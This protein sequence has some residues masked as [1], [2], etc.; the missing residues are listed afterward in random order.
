MD[1]E[2]IASKL[3]TQTIEEL[4]ASSPDLCSSL[5]N[6]IKDAKLGIVDVVKGLNSVLTSGNHEIRRKGIEILTK[7][8]TQLDNSHLVE[9]EIQ[10]LVDFL[11][12]RLIDHSSMES[13]SLQCLTYFLDCPN[14][15]SDYEEKLIEFV[16]NKANVQ[17]METKNRFLVYDIFR[18]VLVD[19]RKRTQTLDTDLFYS[20]I[21]VIEGE[22]SPEN[23]LQCFGTI[24]YLLKNFRDLEP[25]I[26]D[27]FEW[28]SSYYPID[29]TPRDLDGVVSVNILRDDLVRAL[30]NCFFASEMNADNLQTLLLE[31]LDSSTLN[32]K[33]ESLECLKRCYKTFPL[34]S[35]KSYVTTIWAAI[36]IECLKKK[37]LIEPKLLSCCCDI[38]AAL[39]EK[40]NEDRDTYFSF[41]SD[42]YDELSIA[43]RKP[44]MD[45]FEP[46]SRLIAH[47]A[48]P[49]LKAFN[50]LLDKILPMALSTITDSELRPVA[51][52]AYIF[53][54][55]IISHPSGEL[56]SDLS[57]RLNELTMK[58]FEYTTQDK[59]CLRLLNA[60]VRY[61]VALTKETIDAV[62]SRLSLEIRSS[63]FDIEACLAWICINYSRSDI[64]FDD[65]Q[66]DCSLPSLVKQV[67]FFSFND[68][69]QDSISKLEVKFSTYIRLLNLMFDSLPR[70]YIDQLPFQDVNDLLSHTRTIAMVL[71]DNRRIIDGIGT[72]H[73]MILNKIDEQQVNP[74]LM[75]LF[76]SSYCQSLIPADESAAD[77]STK[78]YLPIIRWILKAIVLRN[79][80][81]TVPIVNLI[82]NYIQSEKVH[83]NSALEACR[84]FS[85]VHTEHASC[86][87]EKS[88]GYQIFSLFKQKFYVESSKEI[89][90]RHEK[91][92][93][94]T[95]HKKI[96]L[97]LSIG[98]QIPNLPSNVYKKDYDWLLRQLLVVQASIKLNN[99][100]IELL[101]MIYECLQVLIENDSSQNLCGH[102]HS[103]VEAC[104]AHVKCQDSL[105]IRKL[106]LDCL[107]MLATSIEKTE[108]IK[109]RASVLRDLRERLNDKKRI[110]RQAAAK[111]ILSWTIIG[112]PLGI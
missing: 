22:S 10:V 107:S 106:G 31:K 93:N 47:V 95:E 97:I 11:L 108:L 73:A 101:S 36:R 37:E 89:R 1:I 103:V 16:K 59:E 109:L 29:Y 63:T 68:N 96:M 51:G 34:S 40:L 83:V 57:K 111:A 7:I 53:E 15:P 64:L 104:R 33:L 67:K 38:L 69:S 32:T 12:L 72:L 87:F 17:K 91:T 8:V 82:L 9:R 18:K 86:K 81:L 5:V 105:K 27:V 2:T 13:T 100:N 4:E 84:I 62:I 55:L 94:D 88:Q 14:K 19:R 65:E 6:K 74:I 75:N 23:L 20:F 41:I 76:G 54:I 66:R 79:H 3:Q 112:Q 49:E 44:E 90:I 48:Q 80:S 52:V 98:L 92:L 46:A 99:D 50:F 61:K 78:V 45:L 39:A 42:I 25:Y 60:M 30:Y 35:I 71:Q 85:F 24:T 70:S 28:L 102:L 21:H 56:E 110:V 43:F 77:L 58:I 26:D